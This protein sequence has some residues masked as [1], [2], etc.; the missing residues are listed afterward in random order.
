MGSTL[1]L[2]MSRMLLVTASVVLGL[3]IIW[4]LF[5]IQGAGLSTVIFTMYG[6]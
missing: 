2:S 5:R 3:V 1:W 4:V 6:A